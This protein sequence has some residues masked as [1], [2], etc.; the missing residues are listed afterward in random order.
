MWA[1]MVC[2]SAFLIEGA[3]VLPGLA[4]LVARL[5][6]R[7]GVST[8][9]SEGEVQ[10]VLHHAA[11]RQGDPSQM[12][13]HRHGIACGLLCAGWADSAR[14]PDH[15]LGFRTGGVSELL[16]ERELRPDSPIASTGPVAWLNPTA[17]NRAGG[18]DLAAESALNSSASARGPL[19]SGAAR[20][21]CSVNL[22]I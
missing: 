16:D 13:S 10:V 19:M 11:G 4:A 21:L 12:N 14:T 20:L 7:H 3:G 5:D 22:L 18:S 2:L 17:I 9:V 15:V 1:A 6:A 8:T